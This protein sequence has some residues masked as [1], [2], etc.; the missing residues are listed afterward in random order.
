[1]NLSLPKPE[2][3]L[4][5]AII[6]RLYASNHVTDDAVLVSEMVVEN[7]AR[8]ADIVLANGRLWGFEI[9]SEQD[10]LSRLPGQ[11]ETFS[12]SFEKLTIVTVVKFEKAVRELLPEG[13]GLWVE[14]MD[15]SLKER[16]RAKTCELTKAA[17]IQHM[18]ATE[19]RKLLAC[20]GVTGLGALSRGQL[21][22]TACGLPLSD[23][24]AAARDAVKRKHRSKHETFSEARAAGRQDALHFLRSRMDARRETAV[25]LPS[26]DEQ[27]ILAPSLNSEHPALKR[28]RAGTV[29][30]RVPRH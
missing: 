22:Q 10:S 19:L 8:R 26:P 16:V 13:V 29:L 2:N 3:R 12:R 27:K 7:W 23:L 15:G 20:N 14:M 28:V 9:K 18:T 1:M 21:E 24:A 17:A 4:K 6:D 25:V 11:I 5:T 30:K